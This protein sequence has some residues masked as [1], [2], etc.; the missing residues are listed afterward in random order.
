MSSLP[1]GVIINGKN[2]GF[3]LLEL[4]ATIAILGVLSV[5]IF[6]FIKSSTDGYIDYRVR[7]QLQSQ[8]RFSVE[9]IGRELRHAVP[10]SIEINTTGNCLSYVPIVYPGMFNSLE[11]NTN[12]LHVA[13]STTDSDWASKIDAHR[14]VFGPSKPSDLKPLILV[15]LIQQIHKE[16]TRF[17]RCLDSN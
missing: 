2:R 14:I 15:R 7:D 13:M 4:I 11:E 12:S 5:G 17:N 10:Y 6:G 16:V 3:T 1:I 9:R 8:A